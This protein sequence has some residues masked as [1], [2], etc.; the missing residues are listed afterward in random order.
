VALIFSLLLMVHIAAGAVALGAGL[1]L[2]VLAKGDD[3]HRRIGRLFGRMMVVVLIAAYGLALIRFSPFLLAVAAFS[4]YLLAAG[5]RAARRRKPA[6][7]MADRLI[8]GLMLGV[9]LV[10]AAAGLTGAVDGAARIVMPVF[11]LLGAALA[12]QDLLE[13][14]RSNADRIGRHLSRMLGALIATVTAVLVVNG[15]ALG[16]PSVAAWLVPTVAVVPLI[17]WW[18]V[19]LR[20]GAPGH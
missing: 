7:G 8:A 9:G 10:M 15:D 3:R 12:A 6:P 13:S 18:N 17:V 1:V 19:R 4:S 2:L 11:G 20:R 16:L 5:W 14:G